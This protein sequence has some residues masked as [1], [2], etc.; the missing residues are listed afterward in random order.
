MEQTVTLNGH[1][2]KFPVDFKVGKNWG[3]MEEVKK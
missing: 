2:M 3:H 1:T